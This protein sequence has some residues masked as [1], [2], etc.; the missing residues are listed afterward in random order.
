MVSGLWTVEFISTSSSFGTGVF[1]LHSNR[2]LGGD[3]GYYYA[4][5]YDLTNNVISGNINVTRYNSNIISVFGDID[6]FSLTFTGNLSEDDNID[7]TAELVGTPGM[8]IQIRCK[9]K[10]DF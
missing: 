5:Q 6:D 8:K 3:N 1:A 9:K 10:E 4:G 2:L 7:G